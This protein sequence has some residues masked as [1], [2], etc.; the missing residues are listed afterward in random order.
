MTNSERPR[1]MIVSSRHLASEDGWQAS[2]F[3]YGLIIAYNGFARWVSRCMATAGEQSLTVLEILI[4]HHV[5]HRARQKRLND[6][7]FLLNIEDTHTVNYALKKL[8]KAGLIA[9]EKVGKEIFYRV[10]PV[11]ESL[12]EKYRE[13]REECLIDSI[14]HLDN[15][16]QTLSETAA[17]LRMMSGIY[18]Q[19]SR[20]ASSI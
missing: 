5:N 14:K 19:A 7:C 6:I 2:E 16:P 17:I 15:D 1:N 9:G 4:L 20:A 8:Q 13:I 3:E 18:D 10:T 11:G 12:C